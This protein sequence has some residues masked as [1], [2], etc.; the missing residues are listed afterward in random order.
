MTKGRPF[1]FEIE[2]TVARLE[3]AIDSLALSEQL[4]CRLNK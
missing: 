1:E 2:A 4:L 3:G